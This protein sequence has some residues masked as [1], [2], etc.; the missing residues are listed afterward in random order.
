MPTLVVDSIL[1]TVFD[2][3]SFLGRFSDSFLK[4][5]PEILSSKTSSYICSEQFLTQGPVFRSEKSLFNCH[6]GCQLYLD[7]KIVEVYGLGISLAISLPYP[8]NY[9]LAS[10][11]LKTAKINRTSEWDDC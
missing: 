10:P 8:T 4:M 11:V 6:P 5:L 7:N 3:F 2:R 9:M 1:G